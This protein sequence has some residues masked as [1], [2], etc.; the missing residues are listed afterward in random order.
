LII[1]ILNNL[2]DLEKDKYYFQIVTNHL[3]ISIIEVA[4]VSF[5]TAQVLTHMYIYC[6]SGERLLMEVK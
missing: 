3:T 4:F 6:Y 5:Y 2:L 1:I